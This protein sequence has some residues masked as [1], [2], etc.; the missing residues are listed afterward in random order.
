MFNLFACGFR[1]FFLLGPIYGI[2]SLISWILLF[3]GAASFNP[4][5]YNSLY[6]HQHSM[7]TGFCGA[8]IAGF[9]LTAV[10]NWTGR[11]TIVGKLLALET[12]AWL[13]GRVAMFYANEVNP[14]LLALID[15]SFLLGLF[16]AVTIPIIQSKNKRNYFVPILILLYFISNLGFHGS[17]HKILETS[18]TLFIDFLLAIILVFLI[19]FANRVLPFF[20]ARG[21][22]I[23]IIRWEKMESI[24]LALSGLWLV[25]HLSGK[26][27]IICAS[28]GILCGVSLLVKTI[29]WT[30]WKAFSN[31]MLWILLLGHFL[32]ALTMVLD[33]FR[34]LGLPIIDSN[35]LT[36]SYTI[37]AISII[38]LGMIS[39]VSLGHSGRPI[40][41]DLLILL[42]F[43]CLIA[44]YVVRVVLIYLNIANYLLWIKLSSSLW[45]LAF[46]LYI[47]RYVWI[48]ISPRA[49]G[50]P[51]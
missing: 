44:S 10:Q 39:R 1:P 46:S 13:A 31:P 50:L 51:G 14:L 12:V 28:L 49:D 18:P 21:L 23:Q 29:P 19:V 38:I 9:L 41:T 47:I 26:D 30:K 48:L 2:C 8:I 43:L 42:S 37:G 25:A 5:P 6:I 20:T 3:S 15:S 7:L 4:G 36:H 11:T 24:S 34:N 27:S 40:K 33:S 17:C 35:V 16:L 32:L 22:G 45:I